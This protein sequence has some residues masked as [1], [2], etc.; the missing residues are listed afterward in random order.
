MD[1][2]IVFIL[3]VVNNPA[4]TME[5]QISLQDPIFTSFGYIPR[6]GIA[7]SYAN[8]I[9]IFFF[10]WPRCMA[11]G[12]LAPWSGIEPASPAVGVCSLNHWTTRGVQFLIFWSPPYYFPKWMHWCTFTPVVHNGSLF[13]TSSPTLVISCLWMIVILTGVRWY[14]IVDLIFMYLMFSDAEHI[15][16]YLLAICI[17]S[18]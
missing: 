4:V 13:S 14:L 7:G 8:S 17:S 16:M 1:I 10:F 15:F 12:I 3:A 11:C 9:L 6:G 18:L 5:M 2:Q